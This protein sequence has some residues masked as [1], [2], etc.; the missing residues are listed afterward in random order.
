[1]YLFLKG[2][3]KLMEQRI[4]MFRALA[5]LEIAPVFLAMSFSQAL[6]MKTSLGWASSIWNGKPVEGCAGILRIS[7][8]SQFSQQVHQGACSLWAAAF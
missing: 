7:S 2:L 3:K 8:C 1:M 6:A 4:P 5:G